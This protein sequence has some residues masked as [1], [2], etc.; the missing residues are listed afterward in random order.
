MRKL[1][2]LE[3]RRDAFQ[4]L[5]NGKD[6]SG[7]KTYP[8]QPGDWFVE[9]GRLVGRNGPSHLFTERG[10][11]E[12]FHLRVEA[13]I[14]PGG[15]SG[16]YFRSEHGLNLLVGGKS[17]TFPQGYEAQIYDS[18]GGSD[19][20]QTGSLHGLASVKARLVLPDT[21]FLM[22][23]IAE[24]NH[25]RIKID[26][27]ESATYIDVQRRYS[28]GHIAL[29]CHNQETRVEFRKIEV[30]ELPR[31][32]AIAG[33]T[34][35]ASMASGPDASP[36]EVARF[37]GHG[38]IWVDGISVAPDGKTLLSACQDGRPAHW[39]IADRRAAAGALASGGHPGRRVPARW[40][41]GRDGL[42]RRDRPALGPLQRRRGPPVR[43]AQGQD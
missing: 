9:D 33:P 35:V 42:R 31:T 2:A 1:A 4:P 36:V 13:K 41:A 26:G 32:P 27:K 40:T 6:T 37:E 20:N 11:F 7:W 23:V 18:K 43:R 8:T 28:K 19:P 16:V 38:H 17:G 10:D 34:S 14:N 12:D 29:Q 30:K 22:E 21:W 25:I 15:N 39:D 3:P 24:G 5:F